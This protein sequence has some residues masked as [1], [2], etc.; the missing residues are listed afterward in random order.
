MTIYMCLSIFWM[1]HPKHMMEATS[2]KLKSPP[3]HPFYLLM[4]FFQRVR[5]SVSGARL[6]SIQLWSLNQSRRQIACCLSHHSLYSL[7]LRTIT[8][9]LEIFKVRRF[10]VLGEYNVVW[11][12]WGALY[13]SCCGMEHKWN[14]WKL[15]TRFVIQNAH[16]VCSTFVISEVPHVA[17]FP[18]GIR[19]LRLH[20]AMIPVWGRPLFKVIIDWG[21]QVA[22]VRR[23]RFAPFGCH[24]EMTLW[25][26]ASKFEPA[27]QHVSAF[28]N[29]LEKCVRFKMLQ[30][31]DT[32]KANGDMPWE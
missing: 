7:F 23:H 29:P 14:S 25:L 21:V 2:Y 13:S 26:W 22:K 28:S 20:S 6:F 12:K 1:E 4:K 31:G 17:G 8:T 10:F 15:F 30:T 18:P 32:P 3:R 19:R 24:H 27:S 9:S 16:V 5:G 11:G